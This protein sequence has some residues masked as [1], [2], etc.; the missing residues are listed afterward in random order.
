MI[1]KKSHDSLGQIR[2]QLSHVS[3]KQKMQS[4]IKTFAKGK[5]N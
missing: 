5:L 3:A 2:V 1:E 4:Q